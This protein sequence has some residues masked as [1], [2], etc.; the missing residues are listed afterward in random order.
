M[1]IAAAAPFVPLIGG[2]APWR[3]SFVAFSLL[4]VA[5]CLWFYPWFRDNPRDKSTVNAGEVELIESD[6]STAGDGHAAVPWLRLIAG[7]NIW[8]L[9]LMYACGAYS[10][11]IYITFL[12]R[13]ISTTY[14]ES[15]GLMRGGSAEGWFNFLSGLPLLLGAIGCFAG[16]P[17]TDR[18]I[19]RIGLRWGRSLTGVWGCLGGAGLL[20]LAIQF[21][22]PWVVMSLIGL[23]SLIKDMNMPASWAVCV[24][25]GGKYAGTVSG[26]M[27]M[28]GNLGGV[29]APW[30]MGDMVEFYGTAPAV[31]HYI[32]CMFAAVHVLGAVF[33][34]GV[35]ATEPLL[36]ETDAENGNGVEGGRKSGLPYPD[37]PK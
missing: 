30:V 23:S 26:V 11:Y 33:W 25:V 1:G 10:W 19:R 27:N 29:A 18:L 32:F 21:E 9:C 24:D 36:V 6:R 2:I 16:G 3:L 17:F 22:S 34:L 20:A 13:F 8:F 35:N 7:P 4:G 28:M 15:H 12:P 37:K 31:W 5:W 14:G